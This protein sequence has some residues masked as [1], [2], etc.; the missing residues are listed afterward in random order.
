[1]FPSHDRQRELYSPFFTKGCV[2]LFDDIRMDEIWPVWQELE[3]YGITEKHEC[4]NPLHYS[5]FGIATV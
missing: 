4:T 5:G 1:M 2:I 3:K